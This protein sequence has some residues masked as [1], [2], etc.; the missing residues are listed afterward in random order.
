M[1]SSSRPSTWLATIEG[2]YLD[3]SGWRAKEEEE[4]IG[5]VMVMVVV[6]VMVMV[7]S[8]GGCALSLA[9]PTHCSI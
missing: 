4:W 3:E 5:M 6:M 8:F 1:F 9:P 7:T 2:Q